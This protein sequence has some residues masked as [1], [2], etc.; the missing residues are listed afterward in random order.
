MKALVLRAAATLPF[1]AR[2]FQAYERLKTLR[3]VPGRFSYSLNGPWTRHNTDFMR[4]PRFVHVFK[5][6]ETAT[7]WRHP[8]PYRAYVNCWAAQH[9]LNLEGDFVEC[10]AW[11]GLKAR[12][13]IEYVRFGARD[14]T[15]P[16]V[17]SY[18]GL[19]QTDLTREEIALGLSEKN[20]TRHDPR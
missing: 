14:R 4:G 7:G 16:L 12:A 18:E 10:G 20:E 9:A 19:R 3:L 11:L 2:L 8:G 1:S 6:A 15:F 17:D 13:V 5:V